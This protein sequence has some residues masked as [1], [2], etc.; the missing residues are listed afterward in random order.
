MSDE[1]CIKQ[2]Q[3]NAVKKHSTIENS[4]SIFWGSI[5]SINGLDDGGRYPPFD[6]LDLIEHALL[7]TGE[8]VRA[9]LRNR[10]RKNWKFPVQNLRWN[11]LVAKKPYKHMQSD[12]RKL[13][14]R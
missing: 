5:T 12:R 10:L 9:E 6:R 11:I 2:I 3:S 13:R 8:D 14:S 1:Q 4:V 7:L